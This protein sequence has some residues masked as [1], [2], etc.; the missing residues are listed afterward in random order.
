MAVLGATKSRLRKWEK[1]YGPRSQEGQAQ[2]KKRELNFI[3][4]AILYPPNAVQKLPH[5][6]LSPMKFPLDVLP[7]VFSLFI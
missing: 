2:G 7:T 1:P 3:K 6:K 4:D 5:N